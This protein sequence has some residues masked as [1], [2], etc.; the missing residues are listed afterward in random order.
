MQYASERDLLSTVS[1]WPDLWDKTLD[2]LQVL[3]HE[4]DTLY[5]CLVVENSW[6]GCGEPGKRLTMA[7][8][9][10]SQPPTRPK[11]GSFLG[12][13]NAYRRFVFSYTNIS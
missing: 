12:S 9:E 4:E 8:K 5:D 2:T 10:A 1:D 13:C 3:K 6:G 11:I 7:L